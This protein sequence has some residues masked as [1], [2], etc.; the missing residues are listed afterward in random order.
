M[1]PYAYAII[2]ASNRYDVIVGDGVNEDRRVARVKVDSV[3]FADVAAKLSADATYVAFRMT[4]SRAGGSSLYSVSV[5]TG[6]YVQI[7]LSSSGA[8]G[9]GDYVWS[10]VGNTLAYVR[11]GSVGDPALVDQAYGTIYVYSAGFEAVKLQSSSGN[12]RLL[13]FSGDGLGVYVERRETT[14]A[15]TLE[16]LVY[17]PLSGSPGTMLIKS[18][19][20]LKYSD[21]TLWPSSS[22]PKV[23]FIV[24]GD[25]ALASG[26][27]AM[28]RIIP[29]IEMPAWTE[30]RADGSGKLEGPSALGLATS[31]VLGMNQVLLRRDAENYTSV[32]WTPDGRGVLVGNSH[33]SWLVGM[34]GKRVSPGVSVASLYP[35]TSALDGMS[36][37]MTDNPTTRLV[38]LDGATGKVVATRYLGV[39]PEADAEEMHLQVPYIQQV[40]DTSGGADGN[41]ACGPTSVAMVLA[42][43]GELAPWNVYQQER[44]AGYPPPIAT[45]GPVEGAAFAPYITNE[46]SNNGHSYDTT[47]ADPKGNMLAGLYGAISPTGLASWP[48]MEQVLIWHGLQSRYVSATWDG[49][50][51]AVQ[52]GH[53]V[54]LGNRL[55]SEG[56]ILVVVGY[57]DD[58][59]LVVNDPYGNRF[60]PGYGSNNGDGILYPWKRITPRTALEVIGVYPPPTST[61]APTFT[62]T[63][64]PTFTGTPVPTFTG[65]VVP[66]GTGTLTGT[67]TP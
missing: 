24:E 57:T 5:E 44:L 64:V 53:P 59:N 66:I 36:V 63:P 38:T 39:S 58:G 45:P 25:F 41:W 9:M 1:R 21:F 29:G 4:G 62:S 13:G 35:A 2:S 20:D 54:L 52:R 60:A 19:A 16:H 43:Y 51:G 50:V 23:A 27:S 42:Y 30:S 6:D 49:I 32:S 55:T 22:V 17:L 8:A 15:G 67:A 18:Q 3:F 28:K 47:G 33:G 7:D 37:V 48:M 11:S 61:P 12:D 40:N 31:D 56:H 34:D 10:P 26:N 14:P 65:T 46:Y